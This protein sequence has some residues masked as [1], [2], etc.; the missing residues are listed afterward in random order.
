VQWSG[1]LAIPQQALADRLAGWV[2]RYPD[3]TVHPRIVPD[4][5]ARHLLEESESAQL[6]VV[7][8][9]GRGGFTGMLLGSVS[10]AVT[11]AANVP[12]IVVRQP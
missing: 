11:H 1:D 10:T 4:N 9:R 12:V 2:E 6:V 5:P 8:S 3:V 7:G